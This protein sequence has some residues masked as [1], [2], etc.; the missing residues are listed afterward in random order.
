[1]LDC[2]V[3]DA[4]RNDISLSVIRNY[5]IETSETFHPAF[6]IPGHTPLTPEIPFTP[7][8]YPRNYEIENESTGLVADDGRL[9]AESYRISYTV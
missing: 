8:R 2:F 1:M 6:E 4:P 7:S 9:R 3:A 5:E